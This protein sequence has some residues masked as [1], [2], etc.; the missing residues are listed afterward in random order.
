MADDAAAPVGNGASQLVVHTGDVIYMTGERR[1]YDRNFRRPYS[2]FL[3]EGSTVDNLIFRLPFLP[4]PGNH[5][6]YDLGAWATWLARVPLLG[7]GLR[8]LAHR[9]FAFGLPEGGS[10]MGRAYMEAFVDP[11]SGDQETP[12]R[13]TPGE[14]TR[15]PNRYYQFR[16]GNVDFFALDSNTLD[17]PAP[18]TVDPAEVRRGATDRIAALEKRA[19]AIDVA[20]RREQRARD[21]QQAALRRQIGRD[22][23]RRKELERRA[24]EV[25]QSLV[26]LRTALTAVG[27][28]RLADQMQLVARSWT[29]G[30]ADLRQ[31]SS[32]EDAET[33]LQRL[34]ET[35]DDTCA[36]LGSVE[37]VLADL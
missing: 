24:D 2:R 4:V 8:V 18:E 12:L 37:F 20:L 25:V 31:V 35:S 6:Y 17:A 32:P 3:T 34:D 5:D 21:E 26:G 13:Y 14:E 9:L 28:R 1:L 36:A 10:D 11:A 33:T 29:D 15:V 23:A 30:A 7:R 27:V 22:A 16:A 19:A